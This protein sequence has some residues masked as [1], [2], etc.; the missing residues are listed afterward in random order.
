[1]EK[2]IY[3]NLNFEI[4]SILEKDGEKVNYEIIRDYPAEAYILNNDNKDKI[5]G[6]RIT[7]I[8]K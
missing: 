1:M 8:Y 5:N 2:G 4:P 6:I 7:P 3:I